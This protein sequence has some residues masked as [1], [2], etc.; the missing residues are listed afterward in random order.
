MFVTIVLHP[1]CLGC[2]CFYLLNIAWVVVSSIVKFSYGQIRDL[3]L[4]DA[5]T[6]KLIGVLVLWKRKIV[7]E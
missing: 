5:Y 7:M 4:N 3:G 6:K 2:T 1:A